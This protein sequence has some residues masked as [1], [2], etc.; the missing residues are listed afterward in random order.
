MIPLQVSTEVCGLADCGI[1]SIPAICCDDNMFTMLRTCRK[2]NAPIL[3]GSGMRMAQSTLWTSWRKWR[4]DLLNHQRRLLIELQSVFTTSRLLSNARC[5]TRV[6]D[7]STQLAEGV[8]W[9]FPSPQFH[10]TMMR[11]RAGTATYSP[12]GQQGMCPVSEEY[13]E[14]C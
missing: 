12:P 8:F 7:G 1:H 6:V 2:I 14:A 4:V 10:S 9:L 13:A 5:G 11:I 3:Y